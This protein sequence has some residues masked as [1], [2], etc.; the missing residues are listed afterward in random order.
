MSMGRPIITTD[1]P[2]CNHL[3]KNEINGFLCR[4]KD[5]ID[6]QNKMEKFINLESRKKII[7]GL[8]GRNL[9]CEKYTSEIVIQRYDKEINA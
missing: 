8:N 2:G 7:M 9:V 5:S 6:L 1:V 3:I 4:V